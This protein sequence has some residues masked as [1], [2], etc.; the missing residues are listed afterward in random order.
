MG[1]KPHS[2]SCASWQ[3]R[4]IPQMLVL[5][6]CHRPDWLVC[7][8]VNSLESSGQPVFPA[9]D[10]LNLPLR[11]RSSNFTWKCFRKNTSQFLSRC[12]L[13]SHQW[14]IGFTPAEKLARCLLLLVNSLNPSHPSV[15]VFSAGS[16]DRLHLELS[17]GMWVGWWILP[18]LSFRAIVIW[19]GTAKGSTD[20]NWPHNLHSVWYWLYYPICCAVLFCAMKE[21]S[22][23]TTTLPLKC[24]RFS[25][26]LMD[27]VLFY[28]DM[29][30]YI[31]KEMKVNTW[32]HGV[33]KKVSGHEFGM[34]TLLRVYLYCRRH[35]EW[36]HIDATVSIEWVSRSV[37][38]STP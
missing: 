11:W 34:A 13:V 9:P 6:E 30:L 26:R 22:S 38:R 29:P 10:L 31:L 33:V 4:V 2:A 20:I 28:M 12:K 8:S 36:D 35:Y 17:V 37:F 23:L 7:G 19:I 15:L 32:Y 24:L 27:F 14:A 16:R 21:L 1:G 3:S 5:C 18:I 25:G